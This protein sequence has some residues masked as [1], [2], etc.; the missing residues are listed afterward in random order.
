MKI[1]KAKIIPKEV[2]QETTLFDVDK[3]IN[4]PPANWVTKRSNEFGYKESFE[5]NGMIYPIIV[6]DEKPDWVQR[7]I[8]PKNPQ[9]K[10]ENG[11]LKEGLYVHA[12]NKRVQW[13]KQNNYDKIEGYFVEDQNVKNKLKSHTHIGHKEIPK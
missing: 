9:H 6:S 8:L 3:L 4:I 12:G 13:A 2:E 1:L 11:K 10:D 7:R 5:N